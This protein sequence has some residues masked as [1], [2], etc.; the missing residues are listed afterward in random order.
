M[1]STHVSNSQKPKFFQS[2]HYIYL[3]ACCYSKAC[4]L[5]YL[6]SNQKCFMWKIVSKALTNLM[7]H[8]IFLAHKKSEPFWLSYDVYAGRLWVESWQNHLSWGTFSTP[9]CVSYFKLISCYTFVFGCLPVW[10]E[11]V[12]YESM[13]FVYVLEKRLGRQ[14]KPCAMVE[15]Y[16]I[17]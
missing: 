17:P 9:P 4:F 14:S 12:N 5:I 10:N 8:F 3:I 1:F 13:E 11:L 7:A 2:V 6:L 15:I 16:S